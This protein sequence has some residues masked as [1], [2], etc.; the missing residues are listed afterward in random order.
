MFLIYDTETT[1]L[2]KNFRAPVTDTD[3]WPR[4]VQLAWQVH[5]I[6]GKKISEGNW[7]V[8]PD[9][10]TIPF[11]SEKI[12]GISTER[13]QKEGSPLLDVLE[14][15]EQA[16]H[17]STFVIGHNLTFDWNIL[18]AEYVRLNRSNALESKIQVDTKDSGTEVCKIPGGQGRFKWPTLA[19]LHTTLFEVGFEG[20]HDAFADVRA[21]ARS[22]F[23]MVRRGDLVLDPPDGAEWPAKPLSEV[24]NRAHYESELEREKKWESQ[25]KAQKE[26]QNKEPEPSASEGPINSPSADSTPHPTMG[27]KHTH[28]STVK[29]VVNTPFVHLH[30]HSQFSIL[31]STA[32]VNALVEAAKNDGAPAVACTDLGNMFGAFHFTRAAKEAGI[33]PILGCECYL[34]ADRHQKKFTR[35]FKDYRTQPVFLVKNLEGYKNLSAMVSKGHIEGYYYK[36]PRIDKA[37][38][39]EHHK[40]VIAL[41]GGLR[42]EVPDLILNQ[43]EEAAEEAFLWWKE[44]FGDDFYV[45]LQRH[46][47][48]EEDR[49]NQVLLKLAK[50]HDVKVLAAQ[51]VY[52]I[53]EKD[54]Q[55]HDALLCV[56][57]NNPVSMPI[58]RGRGT[59]YG[60]PNHEY[61][62]KSS[63]EM[64]ALFADM[65]EAIH[66]IQDLVAT[67]EPI[68]LEQDILLPSSTLPEGFETEDDTLKHLA[69]EGAKQKYPT[70]EGELEPRVLERIEH[71]LGIIKSMG[72]AGYFLIVQDFIDAAKKMGVY[73]GPGRG[74]AAG[75]VVAYAIGIT[76]VDP[77]KYDLLFE[78]FLNPERVSMPDMDI[79]F[80]DEGR[81]KVIDYVVEKYGYNQV[82]HI[83]TFGTMAAR[84]AV[85]DVARVLEL[86]L[87]EADQLAKKVPENVGTT[88]DKA[89]EEVP[90]LRE[91][92]KSD[93][94]AGKTLQLAHTLEGSIRNTGIH[95]AG[96]IIAPN[97]LLSLIP[98]CTAKDAELMVTQFDGKV[99]EDAGMLKMDF[100][101]LKTLSILKTVI[102]MVRLIHGREMTLDDIPLDDEKTF[103]LYQKG[104]TVGTF[105]FE[106]DGMRK[107]LR[108]LKPTTIND[109]IAMNA[110]YRPG[111]MQFIPDYIRRKH[112]QEEVDYPH[113]DVVDVL[114]P[115][116]G[117]MIYQ[118]QIMVVAQRM[119]DYT[120]GEADILRRIM[121][122][123]KVDQMAQEEEKFMSRAT[124]KG[125]EPSLAKEIFDKMALFAGY[126]FN[127]SHSAAYSILAYQTM[128]FKANYPAEY[129]AS[130]MSHNM[131]DLKK[132]TYF[133]DECKKMGIAVD[134]PNINTGI[135]R[136]SVTDQR[137]QF[138]LNAIKGVGAA[139]IEGI[140]KERESSGPFTS[141]FD[142]AGRVDSKTCNKRVVESLIQAGAFDELHP[143]RA[144]LL[145]GLEEIM[146][147]GHRKFEEARLNQT[148]LFGGTQ[149]GAAMMEPKL[150][151]C[152]PWTQIEQL[153]RERE[154]IG[155]YL[156]G[157]PLERFRHDRSLFATHKLS[158][159]TLTR[160]RDR[161]P[162]SIVGIVTSIR[163]LKD[164]KQRP[165]AFMKVEDLEGAIEV[166]V[167]SE[168]YDQY[169]GLLQEDNCLYIKGVMRTDRGAPQLMAESMDRAENLREKHQKRVC[170]VARLETDRASQ[171]ILDELE[172]LFKKHKGEAQMEFSLYSQASERPLQLRARNVVIDPNDELLSSL[173]ELLGEDSI[174]LRTVAS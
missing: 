141:I 136:F 151:E 64:A 107:H 78:R 82:A 30:C 172:S 40:G 88:L 42:G 103:A 35:D 110:L 87:Q 161:E 7:I 66:N 14:A 108:D 59:R 129:M 36:F 149:G 132:V 67:L 102:E 37:L 145:Q 20:A 112:G 54:W 95:A 160:I 12:H 48:E 142:F 43:G 93:T 140:V 166:S 120:L 121:G 24:I 111:P 86:P 2:P 34:V 74:S 16:V 106:S 33:Q 124:A 133:I 32:S 13:A 89:F 58:G 146:M 57:D 99:I 94:L 152:L 25:G 164:S 125:I 6:E 167:F 174:E 162:G 15:F 96:I 29:P 137:I 165:I 163:R 11:N 144:Q 90:E 118:E 65:P 52:Y 4:L 9:G 73:V 46:G 53:H 81:Q 130:V 39:K 10:F 123:K 101:G 150:R 69:L 153:K 158:E 22:F 139:A 117:I 47:L 27:S 45:T 168:C 173:E 154:V 148:S 83:I 157:H 115:T 17:A 109:L 31:R 155:F 21:T 138:G 61:Y 116:Y 8:Q 70:A 84:S 68:E 56:E 3:N 122:K 134:F 171:D 44:I 19:E 80:D 127:K 156:S 143:N 98:V 1:G 75:S 26:A 126:G 79:D 128:Y 62:Y 41:T 18:G 77:L 92:K 169:Q 38:I 170:I 105:Q 63:E 91:I 131:S 23:E 113:E 97:D 104:G 51:D 135:G 76:N 100:L 119:G 60:F 159:N 114:E 147:Y 72:F 85:R 28:V 50:A 5:D 55:A 49:V 71:E